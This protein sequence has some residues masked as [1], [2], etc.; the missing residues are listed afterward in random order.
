MLH[1]GGDE[2]VLEVKSTPLQNL[3]KILSMAEDDIDRTARALKQAYVG[4]PSNP[5]HFC[6]MLKNHRAAIQRRMDVETFMGELK[7]KQ[8]RERGGI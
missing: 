7:V 4:A 2:G 8:Y 5:S 6:F 1:R 3:E